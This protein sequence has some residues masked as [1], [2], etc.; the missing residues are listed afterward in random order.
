MFVDSKKTFDTIDHNILIKKGENI[1][2]RGIVINL[3]KCYLNK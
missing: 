1:G 2:L 3:L